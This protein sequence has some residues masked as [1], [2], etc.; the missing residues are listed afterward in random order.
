MIVS[1]DSALQVS[2]ILLAFGIALSNVAVWRGVSLEKDE[3]PKEL[4]D[5]GWRLLVRALA[6]EAL[7]AF[8]LV[9]VDTVLG[10]R[11]QT[12]IAVLYDR[13]T[14]AEL[15]LQKLKAPR[16]LSPPQ[17]ARIVEKLRQFSGQPYTLSV[18]SDPEAISLLK[19]IDTILVSSGWVRKPPQIGDIQIEQGELVAGM[20]YGI[21]VRIHAKSDATARLIELIISVAKTLNDEGIAAIAQKSTQLKDTDAINVMVGTK[22]L[23]LPLTP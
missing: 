22:P 16:S 3:N 5:A 2:R 20:A 4:R 19:I 14:K 8:S 13:A 1:I 6:A 10:I 17:Q 7:L 21:G 9:V 15:E 23:S 11:Q 12:D 18:S